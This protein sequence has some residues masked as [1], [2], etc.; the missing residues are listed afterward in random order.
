LS[1]LGASFE[2][3]N[4]KLLFLILIIILNLFVVVYENIEHFSHHENIYFNCLSHMKTIVSCGPE[5]INS[6][7]EIKIFQDRLK[8]YTMIKVIVNNFLCSQWYFI[9]RYAILSLSTWFSRI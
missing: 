7:E 4:N 5:F 3:T 2:S 6:I 8:I 9:S 1:D